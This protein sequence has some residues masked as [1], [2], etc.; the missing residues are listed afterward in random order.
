MKQ[1]E[2]KVHGLKSVLQFLGNDRDSELAKELEFAA[3]DGDISKIR[4]K[5]ELLIAQVNEGVKQIK[6][7]IF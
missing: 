5:T 4:D 6:K 2:I 1:Y 3:R 7:S